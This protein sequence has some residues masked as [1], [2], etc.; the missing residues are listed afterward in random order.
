MN[1]LTHSEVLLLRRFAEQY[2]CEV[3][4][5]SAIKDNLIGVQFRFTD[6]IWIVFVEDEYNDWQDNN[7]LMCL[8]L[9]MRALEDYKEEND[10]L[11]WCNLYGLNASDIEW[12]SYYKSLDAIIKE[13]EQVSGPVNSFISS[14]DY[15][16]RSGAF[17][18]LDSIK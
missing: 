14:L 13:L 12:L 10:F 15:Q 6:H 16:L 11:K 7:H 8:F 18:E 4:R 2:T 17:H 1:T 5:T 9:V 3:K